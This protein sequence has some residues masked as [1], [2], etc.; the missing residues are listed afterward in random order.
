MPPADFAWVDTKSL[1]LQIFRT[2]RFWC[3]Q[4]FDF[5]GA[6]RF[7]A[8]RFSAQRFRRF[9]HKFRGHPWQ[10]SCAN[11]AEAASG[12]ARGD[13]PARSG[14]PLSCSAASMAITRSW[15]GGSAG[16]RCQSRTTSSTARSWR[17]GRGWRRARA[18]RCDIGEEL[19]LRRL[20]AIS[21]GAAR[22]NQSERRSSF[23]RSKIRTRK[24]RTRKIY[25][26][27]CFKISVRGEDLAISARAKSTET[28]V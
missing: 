14:G 13:A 6:C 21:R 5:R 4:I 27:S 10:P 1:P 26:G 18:R 28:K 24:I 19:R 22:G 15:R 3:P 12:A 25:A 8:R 7:C 9:A 2:C 17:G 11:A 20:G 23:G 16:P